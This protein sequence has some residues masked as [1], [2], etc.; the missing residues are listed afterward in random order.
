MEAVAVI[1]TAK[2]VTA[3][4]AGMT[5]KT[6]AAMVMVM[7][8]VEGMAM[9]A[10]AAVMEETVIVIVGTTE[11]VIMAMVMMVAEGML[12]CKQYF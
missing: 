8:V 7:T 9:T 11:K 10:A 5:E 2:M 4:M 1:A 6:V 12:V 3:V